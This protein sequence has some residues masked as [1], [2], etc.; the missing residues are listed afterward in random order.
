LVARFPLRGI[1][2]C[3]GDSNHVKIESLITHA[4]DL[5]AVTNN[6]FE[7]LVTGARVWRLSD[8]V[9]WTQINEDGFGDSNTICVLWSNGMVI[10]QGDYL[11]GCS[12]S[13][14]GTIWN[15]Q[16]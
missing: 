2:P 1:S 9:S 3:F 7:N 16:R 8:G 15:L 13:A 14:G 6:P 5:Y 11:T 4:G 10:F 12:G